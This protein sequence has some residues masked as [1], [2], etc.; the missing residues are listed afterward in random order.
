MAVSGSDQACMHAIYRPGA[1]PLQARCNNAWQSGQHA[2]KPGSMFCSVCKIV[3]SGPQQ[4]RHC[5]GFGRPED[6]GHYTPS[7]C[8]PSPW[9]APAHGKKPEPTSEPSHPEPAAD[10]VQENGHPPKSSTVQ[11][12][13]DIVCSVQVGHK[14]LLKL[15]ALPSASAPD[16]PC[17]ASQIHSPGHNLLTMQQHRLVR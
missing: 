2:F 10:S 13:N 17:H 1:W 12:C 15:A 3:A 16:H 6:P 8:P 9:D 14:W 11:I 7:V 4:L 5:V